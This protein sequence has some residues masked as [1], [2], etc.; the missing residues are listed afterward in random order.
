VRQLLLNLTASL[1]GFIAEHDGGIDWI[2]PPPEDVDG[3]PVDYLALMESIDTLVMGRATYELSRSLDGGMD[4]FEGRRAVVFTSR[5]DLTARE[6]V[7]FVHADAATFV[8]RLKREAG[9]AIWLFGGGE[10]A[11]ALAAAGLI[12]DYLIVVQPVLLGTGIRLWQPGLQAIRLVL[13]HAREWPGG[14]VEL[15]YRPGANR[16]IDL[17]PEGRPRK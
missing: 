15:R 2:Q 14:L 6:G 7:E 16:R 8:D 10:L 9:G 1:D 4:V 11:T 17:T 5:R 3:V 13:V 12:D